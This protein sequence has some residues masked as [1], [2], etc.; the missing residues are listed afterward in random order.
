MVGECKVFTSIENNMS[1][2][3][4]SITIISI[5]VSNTFRELYV[6]FKSSY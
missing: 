5:M 1:L 2:F 6:E 3:K 4:L